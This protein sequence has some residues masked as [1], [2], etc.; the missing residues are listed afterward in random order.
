MF[1]YGILAPLTLMSVNRRLYEFA[2][3]YFREM[4]GQGPI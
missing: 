3:N 4:L 1:C 2:K